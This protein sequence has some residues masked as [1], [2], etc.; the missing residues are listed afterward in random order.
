[1]VEQYIQRY[2]RYF[3]RAAP[4]ECIQS[5]VSYLLSEP[6]LSDISKWIGTIGK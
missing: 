5:V 4:E 6:I 1:M 2:L 3:L